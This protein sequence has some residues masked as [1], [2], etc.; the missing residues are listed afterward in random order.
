MKQQAIMTFAQL[1]EGSLSIPNLIAPQEHHMVNFAVEQRPVHGLESPNPAETHSMQESSGHK[2][3]NG[4][5]HS[6]TFSAF[7]QLKQQITPTRP[8]SRVFYTEMAIRRERTQ[9]PSPQLPLVCS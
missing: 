8:F 6:L 2:E 3:K 5:G 9:A 4:T 1:P 7:K